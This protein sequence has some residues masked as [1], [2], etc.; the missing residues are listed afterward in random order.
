MTAL[1]ASAGWV[2]L[3][4]NPGTYRIT[5][6]SQGPVWLSGVVTEA[7]DDDD[8]STYVIEGNQSLDF[9]LATDEELYARA[10]RNQTVTVTEL[11]AATGFEAVA[12]SVDALAALLGSDED[13]AGD[14][15]GFGYLKQVTENTSVSATHLPVVAS[16][17][18]AVYSLYKLVA[19]Y[20]GPVA[21][22]CA[23]G[24]SG[25]PAAPMDITPN[26]DG[27]PNLDAAIAAFGTA[28]H[29][30]KYYDQSGNGHHV[31]NLTASQRGRIANFNIGG[32]YAW[33]GSDGSQRFSLPVGLVTER[34]NSTLISVAAGGNALS[35]AT[36]IGLIGLST[37][38][39][40]NNYLNLIT[41]ENG[42]Q[43]L[44][45][46]FKNSFQPL[47]TEPCVIAMVGDA[48][49]VTFHRD[50][51][52]VTTSAW[53]NVAG[54]TGGFIG[55]DAASHG[56]TNHRH[57][58]DI[59][60]PALDSTDVLAVKAALKTIFAIPTRTSDI[61]FDGDSIQHGQ[62]STSYANKQYALIGQLTGNP[63]MGNLGVSGRTANTLLTLRTS[64]QFTNFKNNCAAT[65]RLWV[66]NAG[67]N[68]LAAAVTAD[69][70]YTDRILPV[71]QRA[72]TAG[73]TV[74]QEHVIVRDDLSGAE[75]IER[76]AYNALL[77]ANKAA[78]GFHTVA[79]GDTAFERTD[80]THPTTAGYAAMAAIA[81]IALNLAL[82]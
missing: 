29:V 37:T 78:E 28:F 69:T 31:E 1:T 6:G 18:L 52:T 58:A 80:G 47:G 51:D 71:I 60:Y 61:I 13:D 5:L 43:G 56:S 66:S 35:S 68:D 8:Y 54:I 42:V 76:Q 32:K 3:V 73:F 45:N 75:E 34:H 48:A 64:G 33:F 81:S 44:G 14:P 23:T 22:V 30:W 20:S 40:V 67:S 46:S 82:A 17:P 57:Y 70:L 77:E 79:Y 10:K 26:A 4:S 16:A 11:P 53:T 63:R 36:Q 55:R 62:G 38:N 59:I 39:S 74:V 41:S 2:L 50:D 9:T 72:I 7:P 15:T 49:G 21:S 24:D 25:T 19:G 27:S 65:K 12:A